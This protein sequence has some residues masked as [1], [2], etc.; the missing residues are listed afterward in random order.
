MTQVWMTYIDLKSYLKHAAQN[1]PQNGFS[2]TRIFLYKGRIVD[3]SLYGYMI[4]WYILCSDIQS[5]LDHDKYCGYFQR[6][7]V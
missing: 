4:F 1:I 7:L 3:L 6:T 2:L 5:I